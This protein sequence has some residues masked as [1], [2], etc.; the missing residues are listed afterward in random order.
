MSQ[1]LNNL[2]QKDI[3][4]IVNKKLVLISEILEAIQHSI[5]A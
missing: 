4:Y 5:E 3:K 1:D 2:Q